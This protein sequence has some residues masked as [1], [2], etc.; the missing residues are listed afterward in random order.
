M[1][2]TLTIEDN[3]AKLLESVRRA[4]NASLEEI[5][6]DALRHGLRD[7]T[8][9]SRRGK[10]Y[11]TGSASLGHCRLTNLDDISVVIAVAEGNIF[12]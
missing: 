2:T 4:R 8:K 10:P 12:K 9:P 5:I 11:E 7:V 3:V 1:R 6:N